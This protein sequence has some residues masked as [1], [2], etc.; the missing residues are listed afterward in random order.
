M[1]ARMYQELIFKTSNALP[2]LSILHNKLYI[3]R[4]LNTY[5]SKYQKK[6]DVRQ[7]PIKMIAAIFLILITLLRGS[8]QPLMLEKSMC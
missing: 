1:M 6:L 3:T 5:Q 4:S 8:F 7:L 2:P